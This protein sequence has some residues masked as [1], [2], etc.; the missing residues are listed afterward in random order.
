MSRLMDGRRHLRLQFNER[1]RKGVHHSSRGGEEELKKSAEHSLQRDPKV[2]RG[3]WRHLRLHFNERHRKGVH[4]SSRGGEEELKSRLSIP[5][6]QAPEVLGGVTMI[7][8]FPCNG[9]V[10]TT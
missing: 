3:G 5:L 1:H 7:R 10:R 8:Q 9:F 4:H 6:L 2:L